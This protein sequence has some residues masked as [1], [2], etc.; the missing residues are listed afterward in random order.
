MRHRIAHIAA[1]GLHWCRLKSATS[2]NAFVCVIHRP[3]RFVGSF[4]I[5][6]EAVTILHYKF[7]RTHQTEAWACFVAELSLNLIDIQWQLTIRGNDIGHQIGNFFFRCWTHRHFMISAVLQSKHIRAHRI[8]A[9]SLLPQFSWLKRGH[10]NF[11]GTS[12][13]HFFADDLLNFLKRTHPKRHKGKESRCCL[14][15]KPRTHQKLVRIDF[16]ILRIF[17]QRLNNCF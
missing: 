3:I 16:G 2:K 6:V 1:I 5:D 10:K 4:S 12:G 11:A 13:I 14:T 17:A 8:P 7:L 9:T 15:A